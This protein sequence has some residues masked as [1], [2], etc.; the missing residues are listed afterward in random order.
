[1]LA[2]AAN[3][4]VFHRALRLR[5]VRRVVGNQDFAEGVAFGS[6]D[7]EHIQ[8]GFSTGSFGALR[9]SA[10][11]PPQDDRWD[12]PRPSVLRAATLMLR[13]LPCGASGRGRPW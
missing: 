4:V 8:L 12:M 5:P 2:Q 9:G 11:P 1:M 13:T 10:A 7:S 6:H 3:R